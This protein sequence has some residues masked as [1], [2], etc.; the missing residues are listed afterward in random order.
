VLP[1]H[2]AALYFITGYACDVLYQQVMWGA[3]HQ[4][5][6]VEDYV[7]DKMNATFAIN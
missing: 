4:E 6:V 5:A 1:E 7:M 3:S 2:L